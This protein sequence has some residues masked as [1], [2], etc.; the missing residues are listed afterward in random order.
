MVHEC[1]PPDRLIIGAEQLPQAGVHRIPDP[2]AA[3]GEALRAQTAALVGSL[4]RDDQPDK[5]GRLALPPPQSFGVQPKPLRPRGRRKHGSSSAK[6][7][8]RSAVLFTRASESASGRQRATVQQADG[9]YR[10]HLPGHHRMVLAAISELWQDD[11][12]ASLAPAASLGAPVTAGTGAATCPWLAAPASGSASRRDQLPWGV[13]LTS[14]TEAQVTPA[15]PRVSDSIHAAATE[16]L[17]AARAPLTAEELALCVRRDAGTTWGGAEAAQQ[18]VQVRTTEIR[19][20]DGKAGLRARLRS[21]M[22]VL[23]GRRGQRTAQDCCCLV[24]PISFKRALLSLT[25]NK[26]VQRC[27][28]ALLSGQL[29]S[30]ASAE[31]GTAI[32]AETGRTATIA[33][34]AAYALFDDRQVAQNLT[35]SSGN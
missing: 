26:W 13:A 1:R 27:A 35:V 21:E 11:P 12:A 24:K 16:A 6:A 14:A 28:Q 20:T 23:T 29:A 3:A 15:P 22:A 18:L 10:T 32:K 7:T 9:T 5:D 33:A 30:D 4:A 2:C 31:S 34:A 19:D 17:T 8:L 25:S